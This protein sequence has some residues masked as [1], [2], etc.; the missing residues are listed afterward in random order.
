MVLY[1]IGIG[2]NDEK[3]ISLKGLSIVKKCSKVYL[4]S[5]TSKLNSSLKKMEKLYGKKVIVADRDMVEK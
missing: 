1:L 2:L 4:E 5:Y 3:D